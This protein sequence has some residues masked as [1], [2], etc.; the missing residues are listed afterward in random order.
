MI[1]SDIQKWEYVPLG[2]FLAKN[3]GTS[4]SPWVVTMEA[5]EPFKVANTVQEPQP[6][7]YLTHNDWYNFDINLSV[8]LQPEND[9]PTVV[10]RSNF[11]YLYWSIKQQLT[12]HSITGCNIRPG[13][14]LATGT[15]SGPEPGSYGSMLEL[16]WKGTKPILLKNGQ[17]RTYLQ[18]KDTVIL[19]GYCQARDY[20]IGF[21]K[22][23]GTLLPALKL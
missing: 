14:L 21:G 18:D 7:P 23:E 22:C 12:H 20:R 5:L 16:A 11:K 17:T 1:F 9:E 3:V 4:I 19:E 8:S 6:F 2:P 13:D 15:I 10:C